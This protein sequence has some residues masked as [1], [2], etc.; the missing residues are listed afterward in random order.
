M[1]VYAFECSE[2]GEFDHHGSMK[3][4]PTLAPCP[5]CSRVGMRVFTVPQFSE[6]RARLWRSGVDGSRFSYSL[7][8]SMPDDRNGVRSAFD[9][10]GAEPVTRKTM[11]KAWKQDQAYRKHVLETGQRIERE[12]KGPPVSER[13]PVGVTVSEQL[14]RS[15][16]KVG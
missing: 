14:R 2:H 10:I 12:E 3:A 9:A 7:G 11:P 4:P 16:I 5:R 1:A 6:D 15:G 8:R 13:K